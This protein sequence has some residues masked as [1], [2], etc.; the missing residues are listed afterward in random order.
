MDAFD[1][2][3]G[4]HIYCCA[5]F[6]CGKTYEVVSDVY[7]KNGYEYVDIQDDKTKEIKTIDVDFLDE[8]SKY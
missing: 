7:E 1:I 6:D 2:F 3:I 4:L 5:G 8:Y